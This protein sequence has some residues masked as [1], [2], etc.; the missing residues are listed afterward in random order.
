MYRGIPFRTF[1]F[2]IFLAAFVL[3]VVVLSSLRGH[4]AAMRNLVAER[5]QRSVDLLSSMLD[6]QLKTSQ[7]QTAELA[8]ILDNALPDNR[9]NAVFVVDPNGEIV[10]QQ[11]HLHED[12]AFL[13]QHAGVAEGL[14]GERGILFAPAPDG[15][16]IVAYAPLAVNGWAIIVEEP[17]QQ[18][19]TTQLRVTEVAP[20][21]LIP[22]IAVMLGALWFGQ[23]QVVT[24]L[25]HLSQQAAQLGN[26]Y[27]DA[28]HAPIDGISEVRQLQAQFKQMA[29]KVEQAQRNLRDYASAV[30]LGQEEERKRV[31]REL[32]DGAIQTLTVINQE[33]KLAQWDNPQGELADI[34]AHMEDEIATLT[35][36]LRHMI[37]DLRP[38][39]LEEL[40]LVAALETL[41]KSYR[42]AWEMPI[43]FKV[44]GKERMLDS[45]ESLT[46]Y[47]IT[48]EALNNVQQH[49]T[50]TEVAVYLRYELSILWLTISDN[51]IGFEPPDSFIANSAH[52][53]FGLLG[54]YERAELVGA[55]LTVVS[56]LGNGTK[57]TI[58]LPL[59][60]NSTVASQ[61]GEGGTL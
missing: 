16:H 7:N 21:T 29:A 8:Q 5:D 9:S 23:R 44:E 1:F 18:V 43:R 10:Y 22:L 15:E 52:G 56:A 35:K 25:R 49:A 13:V 31:A 3:L 57:L 26:G 42:S 24:P 58:S 47:R 61:N 36:E 55:H 51:G 14:N 50:A 38:S 45:A 27:F 53:H 20:L 28:I 48:Q 39:Y 37:R 30:T 32:H 19:L 40:G 33:V 59:S 17:W 4:Q 6:E 34:L 54:A 46:L 41:I 11:G 12:G 2:T 60:Q